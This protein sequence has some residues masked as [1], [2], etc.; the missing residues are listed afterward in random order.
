MLVCAFGN[1]QTKKIYNIFCLQEVS[2]LREAVGVLEREEQEAR[3]LSLQ[4]QQREEQQQ[5]L[6]QS[7]QQQLR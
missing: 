5:Q 4:Q 6:L 1:I 3:R 2:D 7:W